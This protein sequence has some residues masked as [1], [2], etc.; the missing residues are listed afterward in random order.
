MSTI[1]ERILVTIERW[2]DRVVGPDERYACGGCDD[3]FASRS[4]GISH[5]LRCHPEYQGVVVYEDADTR[6]VIAA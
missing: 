2:L 3:R 5:V 1:T 6:F 4:T